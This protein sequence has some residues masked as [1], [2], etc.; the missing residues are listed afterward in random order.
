MPAV[1]CMACLGMPD[2]HWMHRRSGTWWGL[3]PTGTFT[4]PEGITHVRCRA[5]LNAVDMRRCD[6]QEDGEWPDATR[7]LP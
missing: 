3:L 2:S 5:M 7:W 4:D 6:F 1:T